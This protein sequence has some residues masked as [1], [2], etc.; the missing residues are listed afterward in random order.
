MSFKFV[1]KNTQ[2][3]FI[4]LYMVDIFLNVSF[5]FD[6]VSKCFRSPLCNIIF[7]SKNVIQIIYNIVP[8]HIYPSICTC[9]Y[10]IVR[11]IIHHIDTRRKICNLKLVIRRIMDNTRLSSVNALLWYLHMHMCIFSDQIDCIRIMII[12]I[13]TRITFV[14]L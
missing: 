8:A 13:S 7:N 11:T 5:I 3:Y 6:I 9:I 10:T 2:R 12:N 14:P 4:Y 1:S